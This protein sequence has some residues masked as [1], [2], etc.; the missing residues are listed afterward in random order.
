MWNMDRRGKTWKLGINFII[1]QLEDGDGGNEEKETTLDALVK[2]QKH[3]S[4]LLFVLL[5]FCLVAVGSISTLYWS[6]L[7]YKRF[8]EFL[9]APAFHFQVDGISYHYT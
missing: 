2:S 1:V 5:I 7:T 3:K 6:C 8:S 4:D 9:M